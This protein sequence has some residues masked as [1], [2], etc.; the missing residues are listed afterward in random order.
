MF[1]TKARMDKR[2]MRFM[3][4][5]SRPVDIEWDTDA[6]L[7]EDSMFFALKMRDSLNAHSS[8]GFTLVQMISRPRDGGLVLVYQKVVVRADTDVQ[9]TFAMGEGKTGEN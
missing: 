3:N 7:E 1:S 6:I 9:G 4:E 5:T 2:G 8:R